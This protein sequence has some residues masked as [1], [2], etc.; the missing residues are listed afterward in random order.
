VFG[1]GSATVS[2]YRPPF[3]EFEI[4]ALQVSRTLKLMH[5][6]PALNLAKESI[7]A[8]QFGSD[9]RNNRRGS[10]EVI[11]VGGLGSPC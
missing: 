9:N 2:T 6:L 7:I 1:D 10:G 11:K 4:R 3:E 8:H 5:L